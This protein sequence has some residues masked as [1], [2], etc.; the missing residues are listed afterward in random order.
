MCLYLNVKKTAKT[1]KS[2]KSGKSHSKY[3]TY[4]KVFRVGFNYSKR[5]LYSPYY[6]GGFNIP[7][8]FTP[9][10]IYRSNVSAQ[11]YRSIRKDRAKL[12]YGIHVYT[13]LEYAR[14]ECRGWSSSV[15]VECKCLKSDF[16]AFGYDSEALFTEV[17]LMRI[18]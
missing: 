16:I 6:S 17:Y 7:Y 14:M 18:V 4:Y 13:S 10:Y 11:S 15:V 1:R 8:I 12:H 2:I 3:F 9:G 5:Y